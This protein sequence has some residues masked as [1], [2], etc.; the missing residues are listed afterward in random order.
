[1]VYLWLTSRQDVAELTGMFFFHSGRAGK[2]LIVFWRKPVE[3]PSEAFQDL[4][5]KADLNLLLTQDAFAN[6]E[7]P[8]ERDWAEN[9]RKEL[10]LGQVRAGCSSGWKFKI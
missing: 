1:M 3:D 4:R 2:S 5:D 10:K 8:I 9:L 6:K 7:A